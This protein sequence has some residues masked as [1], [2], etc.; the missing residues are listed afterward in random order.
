MLIGCGRWEYQTKTLQSLL[1]HVRYPWSDVICVNDLDRNGGSWSIG[2]A[3]QRVRDTDADYVFHLEDDWVFPEPVNVEDLVD[4][5]EANRDLANVVLRRQPHGAEGIG[6]YIGDDPDS[7][8][9]RRCWDLKYLEHRKGFWLNPCVY[10]ADIP[11]RYEWERG[12]T[13]GDFTEL[14]L[15]DEPRWRFAVFGKHLDAPRA[16]HIGDRSARGTW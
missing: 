4:I 7:F 13:E 10:P 15:R 8:R 3:W 5:C 14:L 1:E 11:H 2:Q 16:I 12:M 6:G 9:E